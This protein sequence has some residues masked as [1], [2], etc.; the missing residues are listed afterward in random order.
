MKLAH[1]TLDD[2]S[3][4]WSGFKTSVNRESEN[5][6]SLVFR[7]LS[8]AQFTD[9]ELESLLSAIDSR[10]H[11]QNFLTDFIFDE[12]DGDDSVLFEDSSDSSISEPEYTTSST[13]GSQLII[14]GYNTE[15]DL[16][17]TRAVA[18]DELKEGTRKAMAIL[19][20]LISDLR[21]IEAKIRSFTGSVELFDVVGSNIQASRMALNEVNFTHKPR[22]SA[23]DKEPWLPQRLYANAVDR[24][25]ISPLSCASLSRKISEEIHNRQQCTLHQLQLDMCDRMKSKLEAL[26]D[27]HT[28]HLDLALR[29]TANMNCYDERGIFHLDQRLYMDMQPVN[30][31][32]EAELRIDGDDVKRP[33]AFIFRHARA[34]DFFKSV[35]EDERPLLVSYRIG[36]PSQLVYEQ[37][38]TTSALLEVYLPDLSPYTETAKVSKVLKLRGIRLVRKAVLNQLITALAFGH[39]MLI[40]DTSEFRRIGLHPTALITIYRHYINL[41]SRLQFAGHHN[42]C[43][44]V[45]TSHDPV[46]FGMMRHTR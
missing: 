19:A 10:S 40:M 16:L 24:H 12:I 22:P 37:L 44:V 41:Y 39:R 34:H 36:F 2:R 26:I 32:M 28:E 43:T 29:S 13:L 9:P 20:D 45:L 25:R 46:Y 33:I 27:W 8:S 35:G 11:V 42:L 21:A 1:S 17:I 6:G 38:S 15:L 3:N 7:R 31:E 4:Q 5:D 30:F 23:L 14:G 18:G